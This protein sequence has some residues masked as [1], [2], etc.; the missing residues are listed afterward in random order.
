VETLKTVLTILLIIISIVLTI[1]VLMQ[2][3]KQQGLGSIG[4]MAD[5]YW[6]KNKGRSME[7]ML[8]KVTVALVTLFLIISAVLNIGSF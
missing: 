2:E 5:T 3:G 1:A 4:G 6:G 7:G 8:V